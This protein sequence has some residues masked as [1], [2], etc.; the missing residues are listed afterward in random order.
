MTKQM[1]KSVSR[2]VA[3]VMFAVTLFVTTASSFPDADQIKGVESMVLT[4]GLGAVLSLFIALALFFVMRYVL[5]ENAKREDKLF[6]MM[7]HDREL[8]AAAIRVFEEK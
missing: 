3:Y 8:F 4:I 2:S 6:K 5:T 1:N 7:E